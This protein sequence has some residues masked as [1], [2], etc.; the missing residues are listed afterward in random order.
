MNF[1]S[2]C[3]VW[4]NNFWESSLKNILSVY[5]TT[6]TFSGSLDTDPHF[7]DRSDPCGAE[8]CKYHP[9]LLESSFVFPLHG[10]LS[11]FLSSFLPFTDDDEMA[12]FFPGGGGQKICHCLIP[13]L[14]SSTLERMQCHVSLGVFDAGNLGR[15][16]WYTI[17]V[18]Y[19]KNHKMYL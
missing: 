14:T 18:L 11:S 13:R 17:R 4:W 15:R 5:T 9:P 6:D 2:L 1:R 7:V 19:L 10:N 12:V 16:Y 8:I 3:L